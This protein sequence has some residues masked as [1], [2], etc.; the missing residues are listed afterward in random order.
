M[1]PTLTLHCHKLVQKLVLNWTCVHLEDITIK[2]VYANFCHLEF[3]PLGSA[4]TPNPTSLKTENNSLDRKN[5]FFHWLDQIIYQAVF[6]REKRMF[7]SIK[8]SGVCCT[9][10][11]HFVSFLRQMNTNTCQMDGCYC[12]VSC[13]RGCQHLHQFLLYFRTDYNKS[14]LNMCFQGTLVCSLWKFQILNPSM[15][16]EFRS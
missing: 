6:M 5:M 9:D 15:P 1:Q 10:H 16:L 4:V 3:E 11:M 7:C 13:S 14:P 2:L 8:A 12:L